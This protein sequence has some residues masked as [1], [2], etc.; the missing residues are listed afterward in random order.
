MILSEDN[1]ERLDKIRV[2]PLG[3][4]ACYD[5]GHITRGSSN[6]FYDPTLPEDTEERLDRVRSD[7]RL[8]SLKTGVWWWRPGLVTTSSSSSSSSSS[9]CCD[10]R[11]T[12]GTDLRPESDWGEMDGGVLGLRASWKNNG[13]LVKI[14]NLKK[15]CIAYISFQ[16][17]IY[18]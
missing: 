8:S 6:C 18:V 1:E 7:M 14:F 3:K 2:W 9:S 4:F 10:L 13:T 16:Q 5:R 12:S 17:C 15:H 11:L